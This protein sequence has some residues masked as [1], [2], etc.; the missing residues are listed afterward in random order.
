MLRR[1]VGPPE[2]RPGGLP[3]GRLGSRLA[4][5][6]ATVPG[7]LLGCGEVDVTLP[8]GERG[9]R[10]GRGEVHWVA[11]AAGGSHTCGLAASGAL[12]CWGADDRGQL[13][14]GG[15][16]SGASS[17]AGSGCA[18]PCSRRPRAVASGAAFDTVVAGRSHSCALTPRGDAFCWGSNERGQVGDST[19]TDRPAPTP[20]AGGLSF[21]SLSAGASHTCGISRI[22]GHLFC[23]GDDFWGQLGRRG[24]STNPATGPRFILRDAR[25]VSAGAHHT[26][27]L[28]GSDRLLYCWG[29][30]HRGQ[31]GLGFSSRRPETVPTLVFA[32]VRSV[33]A[34]RL[35]TCART[36]RSGTARCWGWN[37]EGAVGIGRE[38]GFEP[39]PRTV[40]GG[41]EFR[42]LDA[43]GGHGCAVGP[44]GGLQCWGDD[45]RG[46]L[47]LGE[48]GGFRASPSRVAADRSFEAVTA[49]LGT[50]VG[51]ESAAD[52]GLDGTR[53]S[54]HTCAVDGAGGLLCW[55]A[56]EHGQL[57]D[58]TAT[59]RSTPVPV[60]EPAG[61]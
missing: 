45:L 42:A 17:G 10:T 7:A 23:W 39:D 16:A 32:R 43:G 14:R 52:G 3:L 6:L 49:G 31:L 19:R 5:L 28:L 38:S 56:N 24:R 60:A 57:G 54:A 35:H 11:V 18:G 30:N 25:A 29:R 44:R 9:G 13:G 33:S 58:G 26:C 59:N 41:R 53:S 21:R 48:P 55:G 2:A 47:G 8:G 40:A 51:R 15:A 22:R 37:D 46:Q 1:D 4:L 34:G 20:V 36:A 12:F 50:P 27:A 61:G